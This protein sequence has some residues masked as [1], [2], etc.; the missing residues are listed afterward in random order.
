M[1]TMSKYFYMILVSILF[2]F[3]STFALHSE[4]VMFN[5]LVDKKLETFLTSQ[6]KSNFLSSIIMIL[7]YPTF[8]NSEYYQIF[9]EV[10]DYC[11]ETLNEIKETWNQKNQS[12]LYQ[13]VSSKIPNV[14][15]DKVKNAMVEWHNEERKNLGYD[16]YRYQDILWTSATTWVHTIVSEGRSSNF[17]QRK[18]SDGYYSYASILEWLANLW[19]KFPVLWWWKTSFSESVGYGYYLCKKSDCTDDLIK[20]IKTTWDGLIMKEKS[21]QWSHYRAATMKHFTDMGIWIEI[22]EKEKRYYLV[23]HYGVTPKI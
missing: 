21:S 17:H 11:K 2:S 16:P 19:I 15:F 6:E 22:N 1:I 9:Q 7:S 3:C 23:I 13:E 4:T 12:S 18:K 14:N 8:T 20:S 5:K 10:S